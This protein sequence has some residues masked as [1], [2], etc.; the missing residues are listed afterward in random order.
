MTIV[1]AGQL[2]RDAQEFLRFKRAMGITHW[3]AEFV[4][5]GFVRFVAL[6]W[7]GHEEVALEDAV[8]RWCARIAVRKPVIPAFARQPL[9][10]VDG[11]EQMPRFSSGTQDE[12]GKKG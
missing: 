10:C 7:S 12:G 3:R 2:A 9:A 8:T 5:N 6:H 1:T 11:Q 4:L